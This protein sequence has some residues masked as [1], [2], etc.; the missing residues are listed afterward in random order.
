M[1]PAGTAAASAKVGSPTH[2]A[3][4]QGT[5]Y[6]ALREEIAAMMHIAHS[7]TPVGMHFWFLPVTS[8]PSLSH[9]PFDF[10][11]G[12]PTAALKYQ[13]FAFRATM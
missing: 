2:P 7:S 9:R 10:F 13:L 8:S 12:V 3:A 6:P 11:I 1:K 4:T 5:V